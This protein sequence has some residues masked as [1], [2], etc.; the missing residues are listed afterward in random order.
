MTLH[1][2]ARIASGKIELLTPLPPGFPDGEAEIQLS[3]A[4]KPAVLSAGVRSVPGF[5]QGVLLKS[6]EEVWEND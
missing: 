6:E 4:T 1:L 2:K 5:V 3:P